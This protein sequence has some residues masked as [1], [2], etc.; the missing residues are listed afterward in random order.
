MRQPGV[1]HF[2][3]Q[4]A[5]QFA[6]VAGVAQQS[7]VDV[8]E[9]TGEGKRVDGGITHDTEGVRV[10]DPASCLDERSANRF[11]GLLTGRVAHD[12]HAPLDFRGGLGAQRTLV[13]G[14]HGAGGEQ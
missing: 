12:L 14:V 6:H 7:G 8:H 11:K 4:H 1:C 3:T 2:V 5:C 9:A 13:A 10:G